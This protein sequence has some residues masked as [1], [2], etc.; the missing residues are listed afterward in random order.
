M[1]RL[2]RLKTTP[3]F[4]DVPVIVITNEDCFE[5]YT[6]FK[7]KDLTIDLLLSRPITISAI[8]DG[9]TRLLKNILKKKKNVS[10][11]NK[12]KPSG[13]QQKLLQRRQPTQDRIF[14]LSTT[15]KMS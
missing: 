11:R 15:I 13:R 2:K 7:E 1:S 3:D 4:S 9:V 6:D 5:F 12:L 10:H 8:S 14:S